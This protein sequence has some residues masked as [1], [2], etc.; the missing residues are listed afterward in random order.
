MAL[1]A[2]AGVAIDNARLYAEAHH[3]EEAARA[4]TEVSVA[5]LC[6]DDTHDVLELVADRARELTGA[7]SR[8]SRCPTATPS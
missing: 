3:R 7:T 5:L 8:P 1:A 6:G 2:A 4:S